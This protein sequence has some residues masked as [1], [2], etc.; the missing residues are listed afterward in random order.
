MRNAG[1]PDL[2]KE[3]AHLSQKE[4]IEICVLQA[5]RNKESR[6]YLSFLLFDAHNKQD[7]TN[8]V[9]SVIDENF[10]EIQVQSNLYYVKKSLRKVLRIIV[11]YCGYIKDDALAAELHIYFCLKLKESGIPYHKSQLIVNIMD[12][13]LKRIENLISKLHPDLQNDFSRD[14]EKIR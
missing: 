13:Q 8:D 4:L 6:D 12:Q 9:K 14:L 5:R 2:K 1:I 10:A 11:R 3:L 7:F